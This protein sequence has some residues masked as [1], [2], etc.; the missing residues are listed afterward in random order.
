MAHTANISTVTLRGLFPSRVISRRGDIEW[1]PRSLDINVCDFSLWGYMKSNVYENRP[2][3]A[4]DLKLNIRNEV[5]AI[6]SVMLQRVMRNFWE[7][8]QECVDNN[9]QHLKDTLFKK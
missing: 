5:A 4:A 1:P 9:G 8:L 7:R 6:P 2:R 3:T